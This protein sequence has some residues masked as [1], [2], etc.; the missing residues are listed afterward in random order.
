[1]QSA[2]AALRS[3][4]ERYETVKKGPDEMTLA[5]A[6]QAVEAAR[7]ATLAAERRH[8][9]LAAGP[10]PQQIAAAQENA[11]SARATLAE[12]GTR[13]AELSSRP[14][15]AELQD[16]QDRVDAATAALEQSRSE[17]EIQPETDVADPASFDLL[18]LERNVEQDRAQ[19]ETL[20]RDLA[21]T[22]LV[23][24]TSGVISAVLVRAGDPVDRDTHVL[25]IARA[26]DPIVTVDVG[27]DDA[28]R[29]AAGQQAVVTVEGAPG[30]EHNA[31]VIEILAAPG[32]IGN[33]AHLDV[34]W[35]ATPPLFGLTTQAVVTLREKPGVLLVP[36]RAIR[37]AGPRR[38]VE[39]MDGE[40]R[41]TADVTTGISGALDVEIVSGLQEGQVIL[42]GT[43]G[44]PGTAPSPTS[45][46]AAP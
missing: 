15:R 45:G 41:R 13:L 3:A 6:N 23:A 31:R 22:N 12:A 27:A 1:M 21:A 4:Q 14:T 2:E 19:V 43:T 46:A 26:G 8:L 34:S 37:S 38:Y 9:D 10:P 7:S 16:A 18:V 11:R 42:A 36:Q 29:I 20:E 25:S 5:A 32:G 28:G 40:L 33:I 24:P 35:T 30:Q 39:Y 44:S 17:L